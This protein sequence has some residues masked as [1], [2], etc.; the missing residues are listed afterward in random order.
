MGNE[1]EVEDESGKGCDEDA[2]IFGEEGCE[3]L[4]HSLSRFEG[5]KRLE[6][7]SEP[8]DWMSF[9]L[10]NALPSIAGVMLTVG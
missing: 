5:V 1:V 4:E 3:D 9:I 10:G 8:L 2:E 7:G 6:G